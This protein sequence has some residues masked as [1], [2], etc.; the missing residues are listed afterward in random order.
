MAIG[1]DSVPKVEKPA[2]TEAEALAILERI[3]RVKELIQEEEEREDWKMVKMVLGEGETFPS[4]METRLKELETELAWSN[5]KGDGDGSGKETLDQ[6]A[7]TDLTLSVSESP[8]DVEATSSVPEN[9][10]VASEEDIQKNETFAHAYEAAE[11]RGGRLK[12]SEDVQ[13]AVN[14][15]NESVL[16]QFGSLEE[17]KNAPKF[18][19]F[20]AA[21]KKF[22]K[23][24]E[25]AAREG[26]DGRQPSEVIVE[27]ASRR[28][29]EVFGYYDTLMADNDSGE[30][31]TEKSES[32]VAGS[33]ESGQAPVNGKEVRRVK[34]GLASAENSRLSFGEMME[35]E[36]TAFEE[37]YK[38][39]TVRHDKGKGKNAHYED[40]WRK[41][42]PQGDGRT[43]KVESSDT[44]D[45]QKG[46]EY[47]VAKIGDP[48]LTGLYNL[49]ESA[50]YGKGEKAKDYRVIRENILSA[51]AKVLGQFIDSEPVV[52][53]LTGG[54]FKSHVEKTFG[55]YTAARRET[56]KVVARR[57]NNDESLSQDVYRETHAQLE[58]AVK[59]LSEAAK[60]ALVEASTKESRRQQKPQ[61]INKK[62][63][64]KDAGKKVRSDNSDPFA[65]LGDVLSEN[66]DD[67]GDPFADLEK[68]I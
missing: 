41:I 45:S 50:L 61:R 18:R 30:S 20:Y 15:I 38:S 46:I 25:Q 5:Q 9:L 16:A 4:E 65:E 13:Q 23:A 67:T 57:K 56:A 27:S 40:R 66:I 62:T 2:L 19:H 42:K 55:E 1:P 3:E 33:L 63:A 64:T 24:L 21:V 31:V 49:E 59:D 34:E 6:S 36:V 12:M 52:K 48:F 58:Q 68:L 28:Y 51:I 39:H 44:K 26:S 47:Y 11:T 54:I 17:G 32:K 10:P 35:D 14:D 60:A 43:G 8:E 29:L 7:K 22:R 53:R 37:G